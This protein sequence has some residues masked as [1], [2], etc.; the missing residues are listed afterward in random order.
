MVHMTEPDFP[1]KKPPPE[2]P[3]ERG[4]VKPPSPDITKLKSEGKP[5]KGNEGEAKG[6][7]IFTCSICGKSFN[8]QSE[9]DLHTATAHKTAKKV[10]V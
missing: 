6:A 8:T 1:Y 2:N 9:L 5:I 7:G 3:P 4:D 10:T